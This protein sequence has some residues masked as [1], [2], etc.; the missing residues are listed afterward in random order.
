M[1]PAFYLFPERGAERFWSG[2]AGGLFFQFKACTLNQF[3]D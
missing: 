2:S 3:S 1:V